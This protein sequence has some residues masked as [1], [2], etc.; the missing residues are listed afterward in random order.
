[1]NKKV[2]IVG[3]GGFAG[4]F[5]VEEALR[6]GYEVW[7]GLRASTSREY[8]TDPRIR[9][10][11]LDFNDPGSLAPALR[12]ALPEGEKWDYTVY[13][14]GATK[15]LRYSDFARINCDYLRSFLDALKESGMVPEKFLFISSLSAMGPGDEKG[16]TPFRED[17]IPM[18]NT[19]Y[20]T[21][22]HKAELE[23]QM[24]GVPYIIFRATGLY[25]PRDKD[26]FLMFKSIASGFDFSVGL[27]RQFLTF[28]YV[29]D[30]ARA[31]FDALEHSPAGEVYNVAEDA[32]YTQ[33]EF[34]RLASRELGKRLVVPVR[35]P[36]WGLRCVS[37]VA[38][39]I[40]VMRGKPSTLNTDKYR[41][42]KQR[43]W[44]VD[45]SKARSGFGFAP[46][47]SLEEGVRRCVAWYREKGWL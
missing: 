6:R 9:F 21:S 36:I 5:L 31:V 4:G 1:M 17:M 37:Y 22:K 39:K 15:C 42:M 24:S 18:P 45:V 34:R 12:Q 43:N 35:V 23:L 26:Y 47:V 28:L 3:A 20:G 32:F 7:A 19:R 8:L 33:A 46:Q 27:R 29:E 25:G 13:N 2:L 11:E 41:I 30:L 14:L 44:K 38:E 10:L 16:G 40:G